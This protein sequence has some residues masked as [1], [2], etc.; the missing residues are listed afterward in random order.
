MKGRPDSLY[1][2]PEL[3]GGNDQFLLPISEAESNNAR[4]HV[5]ERDSDNDYLEHFQYVSGICGLQQP[6]DW[7]EAL[8]LYN[9]LL[10]LAYNGST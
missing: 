6:N 9:I 3:H 5:I 4:S 10:Q 7:Q 2:L 8:D 1:Y